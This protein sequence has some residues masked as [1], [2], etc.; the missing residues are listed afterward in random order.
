MTH[1]RTVLHC[2][3]VAWC[4]AGCLVVWPALPAAAQ[5]GSI[6]IPHR[7]DRPPGPALSPQEAIARMTVPEGFR[8]ELVACEPDL[9]NPVA[10]TFDERGRIW[11]CESL[12]Y[13]R[14]SAGPGRDRI[15]VLEDTNGDGRADR[16]QVF[17]EGLN[18]PCGIAVGYGGV[19]VSNAPDILFLQ[20]T[21]GDGRADKQE[22][23]VT[24]F[25]RHDTHE[26]PNSF[27]WGPDGWLY[28]L[29]GVFNPCH[30]RY[31]P[32]SPH[33]RADHPGW[34][35]TCAMFRIHPRTREF[36][37]F[38]EGTS[39]PWGIA[40]DDEGSAFVSACVIDHLWHITETGYYHRQAGTYPP[41]TWKIGSIVN[42]THQ[43]AAYCGLHYF[44]SDAYPPQYR[45][46]LYMGNIHGGCINV[47]RLQRDGST[48]HATAEPDFLTA[49]DAWFMPVVQKTGPDGCLYILDWY[50]RYHCYQD[51]NRD[52]EGIDRLHG[53]L[54]RVRYGNVP[55]VFGFDL[56][57][58]SDDQL[59]QRLHSPNVYDRDIAQRLLA[60]RATP[61]VRRKLESLVLDGVAP[62]KARMHALWARLGCGPLEAEFHRKLLQHDDAGFRAWGV[63]AAGNAGRVEADIR[64]AVLRLAG[65]SS[66][67]VR[68]QV[69]IAAGKL[70]G[71]DPLPVW[72]AVLAGC[73]DD[74]LIPHIVWQ[75]LHPHLEQRGEEFVAAA[76]EQKLL[77]TP[78]FGRML[79]LLLDRLLAVRGQSAAPLATLFAALAQSPGTD[80]S[81][82]RQ[83]LAAIA[84]RVQSG[85][86]N[87]AQ[88]QAYQ[89]RLQSVLRGIVR[90]GS[91]HPLYVDAV[92]LA[93]T[94]RDAEALRSARD[95][96]RDPQAP[97][98]A[99]HS[100][101]AAL[102]AADDAQ[103]LPAVSDVLRDV[104][105]NAADFRAGVLDA[106]GRWNNDRLAQL[107]LELYPSLE[108]PLQPRAIELLT[109]RPAWTRELLLAIAEREIPAAAI[110]ENQARRVLAR[111]DPELTRLLHEH[112]GTIRTQRDPQR[113]RLV[114]R[115]KQFLREHP[116]DPHR[117]MAVYDKVCGQCHKIYDRGHEV[118]P[119]ITRNGRNNYQQLLSNVFDPSLVIGRDYQA[120]TVVTT[121]GRILTG[122]PVEE[123]P[124]RVVLKMQGG[125]L[126][127][128]PRDQVEA[129]EVSRLSMMPEGLEKQLR[130]EELADLF[131]FL[132][133]DRPPDD[134]EARRLPGVYDVEPR[135]TTDAAQFN[136][137]LWEVAPQF[138]VAASGEGGVAVL[139]EHLGRKVVVRTH[140]VNQQTPCV[141]R[142]T[143]SL[144]KESQPRL[145][146]SVAHDPRGD[147]QLVVRVA[148]QTLH[149][150]LVSSQSTR[151]GWLDLSFDLTA[152]AGRDV[153]IE[154]ENRAN[155]WA[156]EFGYWGRIEL[157]GHE[158]PPSGETS[159]P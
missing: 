59:L 96:F 51:A 21:D 33:Y 120:R 79:P 159:G 148:G 4:L 31:P 12:E 112:W 64:D 128:I 40:F 28:G 127:T 129:L 135:A 9:V 132:T 8:V 114:A 142:G 118:G 6:V 81:L 62:R 131:A 109:Q 97:A 48:Y 101:L 102:V 136:A 43:K 93:T 151:K 119:D 98:A 15:K 32:E 72:T 16:V 90:Q 52:P 54:Y 91:Q 99:R 80:A 46:R 17:A 45:Q 152:F 145:L 22:V 94:W 69:V 35:F 88:S 74:K 117:G 68:L 55:R 124:Q 153:E 85:E 24:G 50:D 156:F 3:L 154:L 122:L 76:V 42:H 14:R 61:E 103:L 60:Q 139:S 141:I 37:V 125:K 89:Q 155:N 77:G 149:N 34:Q 143:F 75:N 130:P 138:S 23:V 20:D 133:L 27:T 121:D 57:R 115:M 29:N 110:N 26:M 150:G 19:W 78:A 73:G 25:G 2:G 137:L 10:M 157:L 86:L 36:Q 67:D 92:L 63:R 18:I 113:E 84:Q 39:N 123:S 104:Q 5:Q 158:L 116:G 47:D 111:N 38:A 30:V 146:V 66:P 108:A 83:C 58:E 106:L 147:W 7:Q 82:A 87:A 95:L 105:R 144:P 44:D 107:V 71:V 126:E 11:V 1:R 134:P 41:F 56:D 49:N 65:D 13:P 70:Q 53:R 100:A 140:P